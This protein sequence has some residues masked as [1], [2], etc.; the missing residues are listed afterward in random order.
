HSLCDLIDAN[1]RVSHMAATITRLTPKPER[2]RQDQADL[3]RQAL[4]PFEEQMPA[5]A[6]RAVIGLIDRQT[7]SR[8]RWTFV[9]LSPEQN[10]IVVDYLAEHSKRPLTALRVW[11]LCFKHLRT[12]TGEILLNREEIAEKIGQPSRTISEIMSELVAFKA[13]SR[14]RKKLGGMKGPGMVH[15]FMN[16]NVATHLTGSER[17]VAQE[18]APP[19][20]VLMEGGLSKGC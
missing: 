20:L 1:T 11:A 18:E 4:L 7:A 16:P 9:M 6:F 15:Y 2:L 13:I 17:D 14:T 3:L 8:K 12:D 10:A 19:L 5:D